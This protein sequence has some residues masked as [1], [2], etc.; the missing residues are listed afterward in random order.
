ML[1]DLG[2]RDAVMSSVLETVEGT[3]L[4]LAAEDKVERQWSFSML[5]ERYD[6]LCVGKQ[7][8]AD[9]WQWRG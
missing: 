2:H 5:A 3:P 1:A 6:Y 9:L 8:A 4:T 7:R